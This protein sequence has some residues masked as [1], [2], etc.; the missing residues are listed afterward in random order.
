MASPDDL[1]PSERRVFGDRAR[2]HPV[3]G[4]VLEDGIG[5]GPHDRQ[6][7][8]HCALIE[9][10]HGKVAADAMRKRLAEAKAAEASAARPL[11]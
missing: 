9:Q 5:A 6:A 7:A 4:M 11:R 2:R 10:R 3:T 1:T 8:A